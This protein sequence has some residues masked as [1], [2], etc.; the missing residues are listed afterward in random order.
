MGGGWGL[1]GGVHDAG[2]IPGD[3]AFSKSVKNVIS[4]IFN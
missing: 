2:S 1:V 4:V 3:G